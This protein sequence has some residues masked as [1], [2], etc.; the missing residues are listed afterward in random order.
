MNKTIYYLVSVAALL[1]TL[2]SCTLEKELVSLTT[3][4]LS[5]GI[6]SK[7]YISSLKVDGG[8][9]G[10][11][12]DHAD[13]AEAYFVVKG[14]GIKATSS[15]IIYPKV[16]LTS[17]P[18]PEIR[19]N[20]ARIFGV[21][22]GSPFL[23]TIPVTG[24]RPIKFEVDNLPVGLV[25]DENTGQITGIID[26]PGE[27]LTTIRATNKL[28]AKERELK[29]VCGDRLALTPPMGWNSWYVWFG[30][31]SDKILREAADAMVS[32]GMMD[33]GY[34]YVN[35]DDGWSVN[36]YD[37]IQSPCDKNGMINANNRFP[38]MKN[39]I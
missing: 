25:C 38:D 7:G 5:V 37:S 11:N 2:F 32:S 6:N 20:G 27:Y 35:I 36:Q 24:Q 34:M 33:H 22:P 4:H 31:P 16:I 8:E 21:R 13:W 28:G 39:R 30:S 19:I 18:G 29:I 10:T 26:N 12:Q 23:F 15:R 1:L 17:K 3:K 9:D 14:R